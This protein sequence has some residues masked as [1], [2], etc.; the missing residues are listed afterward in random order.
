MFV[1]ES[2]D[3]GRVIRAEPRTVDHAGPFE[4]VGP[5][6]SAAERLGRHSLRLSS[7]RATTVGRAVRCTISRRSAGASR[8]R[9]GGPRH[10][11][12]RPIST[13]S[14]STSRPSSTVPTSSGFYLRANIRIPVLDAGEILTFT[15]WVSIGEDD[16]ERAHQLWNDPKRVNEPPY[17][18][19]LCNRIPGYPDTWHLPATIHTQPV[20]VRPVVE[21]EPSEHP[22]VADQKRGID[23]G[24]GHRDR[25]GLRGLDGHSLGARAVRLRASR[26]APIPS[27]STARSRPR[28]AA[29]RSS[30]HR[31]E[32][33]RCPRWR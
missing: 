30:T 10:A 20:G 2:L 11:S 24:A 5:G 1:L 26:R 7:W 14:S 4:H 6:L 31:R 27:P 3:L 33:R 25:R 23:A 15:V 32:R 8:N 18:A 16:F 9:P 19:E 21:L 12:R 17:L 28:R 22:L 29:R 13:A